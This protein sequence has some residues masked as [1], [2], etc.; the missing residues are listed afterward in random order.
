MS[1]PDIGRLLRLQNSIAAIGKDGKVE[2]ADAPSLTEGYQRMRAQVADLVASSQLEDEFNDL[3]PEIPE[4]SSQGGPTG[5]RGLIEWH[6]EAT[7]AGTNAQR[8]LN[9]LGGW[10]TGLVEEQTLPEKI[11]AEAAERIKQERGGFEGV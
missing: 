4:F 2:P 11:Q 1:T 9:Q 6:N 3:F 8:L 7:T 5:G 10:I